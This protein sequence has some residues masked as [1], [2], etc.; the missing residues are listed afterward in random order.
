MLTY[1]RVSQITC[2]HTHVPHNH[3]FTH[4][5]ITHTLTCSRSHAKWIHM[6][7]HDQSHQLSQLSLH[8]SS[9]FSPSHLLEA[10]ASARIISLLK[11]K[12]HFLS[13]R[14]LLICI[15]QLFSLVLEHACVLYLRQPQRKTI[16]ES[17]AFLLYFFYIFTYFCL[18]LVV[19]FSLILY[20][21]CVDIITLSPI[22]LA[23]RMGGRRGGGA[24]LIPALLSLV[25]SIYFYCSC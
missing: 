14:N 15:F 9:H 7:Q 12:L 20:S 16:K 11:V 24:F 8:P 5:T 4:P 21:M 23:A 13:L 10:Y 6:P 19:S 25:L 1:R 2:S 18:L 17:F 3:M 22:I